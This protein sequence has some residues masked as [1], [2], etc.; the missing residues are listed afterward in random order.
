M[1]SRAIPLSLLLPPSEGKQHGGDGR[2][3]SPD[4]GRFSDLAARRSVLVRRLARVRGGNE[5]LLGVGGKHLAEARLANVGLMAAPS[6]PAWRRYTGVVWDGL[7][8]ASLPADAT[9]RAMSSV[10]VVSGLLGLVALDDP[11][12]DYRL[13]MGASL[14]PYG[15]LST[16]WRP[17]LAEPLTDWA[18]RRF[19]VDLLPND[20]RAACCAAD[21]DGVTVTLVERNGKVAGHD[22]KTAK[23]RLA[24]HLLTSCGHPLDALRTWTDARFDLEV[25]PIAD[26]PTW[27]A[28]RR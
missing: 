25:T 9:R 3:W 13:K 18:D 11:T 7:D 27:Q 23:G 28:H 16:W 17:M 10:I 4:G 19:V 6:L 26:H 12:P 15:K 8:V 5:K 14:A 22:A 2:P 20:H 24:R 21:V 1:A